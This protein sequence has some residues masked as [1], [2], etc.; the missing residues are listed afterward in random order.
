MVSG[1][2][3]G[4]GPPHLSC[5]QRSWLQFV[6]VESGSYI[7]MGDP[8]FH[9]VRLTAGVGDPPTDTTPDWLA[10]GPLDHTMHSRAAG[11]RVTRHVQWLPP[12]LYYT[13]LPAAGGV[14][15]GTAPLPATSCPL[16][17]VRHVGH[18]T[19]TYRWYYMYWYRSKVHLL[20]TTFPFKLRFSHSFCT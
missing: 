1:K 9:D 17:V 12:W 3:G 14:P 6:A 20:L 19:G 2:S 5:R 15:T 18:L 7:T 11:L 4:S 8:H 13:S 16:I 10:G